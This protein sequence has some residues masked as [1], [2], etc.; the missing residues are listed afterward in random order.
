MNDKGLVNFRDIILLTAVQLV[1]YY[2]LKL[3]QNSGNRPHINQ[4]DEPNQK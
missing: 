2:T 4:N 3:I 1:F